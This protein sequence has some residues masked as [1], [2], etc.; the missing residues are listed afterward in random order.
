VRAVDEV[1]LELLG[2]II[3]PIDN[4]VTGAQDESRVH[5]GQVV[6]DNTSKVVSYALPYIVYTSNTG[7]VDNPRLSGRRLRRSVFMPLKFV[8]EDR[9]Q[10][11][12]AMEAVEAQIADRHILVPGFKTWK[13]RLEVSTRVRRDDDAIRPDGSPLFS[14]DQEY[15]MSLMQ[16]Q[17]PATLIGA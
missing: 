6:A 16:V 5:D 15:A 9:N 10:V 14:A 11:K 4:P 7:D 8:G 1:M 3:P 2:L 12:A 17:F 13:C